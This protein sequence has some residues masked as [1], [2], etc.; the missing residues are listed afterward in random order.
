MLLTATPFELDPSEML[1][2][3]RIAKS[4]DR[5]LEQLSSNL[6][7]YQQTLNRFYELRM[8]SPDNERRREI[9]NQLHLLR[10]G[11]GLFRGNW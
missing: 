4:T 6:K 2:L 10:L 1:N 3:F 5:D 11:M 7:R 9:V 8:L